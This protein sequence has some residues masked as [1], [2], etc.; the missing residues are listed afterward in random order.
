MRYFSSRMG[1]IV[2][3]KNAQNR[4]TESS[5]KEI[6]SSLA[7]NKALVG[8]EDML[9]YKNKDFSIDGL[10]SLCTSDEQ[11]ESIVLPKFRR[12]VQK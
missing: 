6:H 7:I 8:H 5:Y 9:K 3:S 1:A 10:N 12:L 2:R 11:L 4:K